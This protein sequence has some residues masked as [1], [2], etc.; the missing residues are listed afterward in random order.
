MEFADRRDGSHAGLPFWSRKGAGDGKGQGEEALKK[1]FSS[2]LERVPWQH[3][4][5]KEK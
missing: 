4:Y 1:D 5:R 2:M 3:L